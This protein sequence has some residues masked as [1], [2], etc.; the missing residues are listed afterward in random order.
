LFLHPDASRLPRLVVASPIVAPPLYLSMCASHLPGRS[1]RGFSLRHNLLMRNCLSTR[2]LVVVSPLVVP[3]SRL[4][5]R[6]VVA[7]PLIAPPPPLDA[8]SPHLAPAP[9]LLICLLLRIPHPP[10]AGF[11]FRC[12]APADEWT[13]MGALLI[14]WSVGVL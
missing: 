2:R 8:P 7:S 13:K 9:Q 1:L 11:S 12:W 6:V 5:W 10:P 3:P 4:P 14:S